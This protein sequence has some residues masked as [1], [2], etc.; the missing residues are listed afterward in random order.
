MKHPGFSEVLAFSDE[1]KAII[2]RKEEKVLAQ[3]IFEQQNNQHNT[4]TVYTHF[5]T[6]HGCYSLYAQFGNYINAA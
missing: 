1:F 4:T 2:F 6:L 3:V 5:C